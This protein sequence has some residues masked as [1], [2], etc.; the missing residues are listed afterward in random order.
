MHSGSPGHGMGQGSENNHRY[1]NNEQIFTI[2][3]LSSQSSIATVVYILRAQSIESIVQS[4][5]RVRERWPAREPR[6]T[7][8][9]CQLPTERSRGSGT[10]GNTWST[11]TE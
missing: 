11:G 5:K 7:A 4:Q 2:F 6:G 1:W 10:R 8:L 9:S 3:I